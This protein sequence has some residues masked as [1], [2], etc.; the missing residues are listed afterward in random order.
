MRQV[1]VPSIFKMKT[2]EVFLKSNLEYCFVMDMHIALLGS[3]IESAHQRNKK[4]IV[5]M[6]MVKGISSDE[7]GCEFVCQILKADGVISTKAKVLETAK[8]NKKI[9]ILR[10]FL[11]DTKSLE[12]GINLANEL[13]P[14]YLE[15][16]P[17]IAL[18][19]MPF[20]KAKTKTSIIGGGLVKNMHQIESCLKAGM[21]AVSIS[22]EDLW[23][24]AQNLN[25]GGK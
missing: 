20:I 14:D 12:K 6:D 24:Q 19:I 1:V 18:D 11:I 9:T 21:L 13:E 17:A 16:L 22:D 4:V 5:H 25:N 10:T 2:F 3:M 8:K 7:Y 23:R 15:I